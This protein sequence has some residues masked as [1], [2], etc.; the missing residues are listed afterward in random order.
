MTLCFIVGSATYTHATEVS[1]TP[2]PTP[3]PTPTAT[4][5]PVPPTATPTPL[6][7]PLG[8]KKVAIG[9]AFNNEKDCEITEPFLKLPAGTTQFAFQILFDP[10]TVDRIGK[11]MSLDGDGMNEGVHL[12]NCNKYTL[13]SGKVKQYQ[14][15]ATVSGLNGKT[16]KSGTYILS[17]TVNGHTVKVP[18]EI[19]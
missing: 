18:F 1:S 3:T 7:L 6:V 14:W 4:P 8:L 5:T 12:V 9:K 16:L 13:G 10:E 11:D 15:G 19:E 17:V 2:T